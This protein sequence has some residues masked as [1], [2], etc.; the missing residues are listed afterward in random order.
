MHLNHS[1]KLLEIYMQMSLVRLSVPE[2]PLEIDLKFRSILI[3]LAPEK[4]VNLLTFV[5]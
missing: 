2:V 1:L 3:A 4:N 5:I